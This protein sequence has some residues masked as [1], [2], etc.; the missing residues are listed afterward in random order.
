MAVPTFRAVASATEFNG[1]TSAVCN[2]PTG[3]VDG[4][5]MVGF[6]FA[7]GGFYGATSDLTPPAGWTTVTELLTANQPIV[8][9]YYKVASSEGASYTW[10]CNDGSNRVLAIVTVTT[11]TYDTTTPI[12]TS[13]GVDWSRALG[14]SAALVAAPTITPAVDECLG[15]AFFGTVG[16][17]NTFTAPSGWT[18]RDDFNNSYVCGT[19]DTKSLTTS[20]TGTVTP[21]AANSL[22][23]NV[24]AA[25][26][27]VRPA[28]G[29]GSSYVAPRLAMPRGGI[30]RAGRW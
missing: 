13:D 21:A 3:T 22:Y 8:G 5:L 10:T 17:G 28:A 18:E 9:I 7:D 16:D 26:A 20:A 25:M 12:G 1:D 4:D 14:T 24:C 2:K 19:V 11:G 15:V 6:F 29:G 30:V 27:A 23:G